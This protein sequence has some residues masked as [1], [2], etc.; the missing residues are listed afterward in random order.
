MRIINIKNRNIQISNNI[1]T[2]AIMTLAILLTLIVLPI[3]FLGLGKSSINAF[4]TGNGDVDVVKGGGITFPTNGK[5]KLYRKEENKV[6]ELDLEEYI[7]GVVASEVPANFSEEA[8]K[9]QAVA[10]RTFY[11]SKRVNPCKDAKSHEAEVCDTNNCQVYMSKEERLSKWSSKDGEDNW[12][13]IKKAVY[14]TKGQILTYD[15]SVLEYPQFFATSSGKTEDAKDVFSIDVPY[16]KSEESK[17]E[18]NAPKFKTNTEIPISEFINKINAKYPE[19]NVKADNLPSQ[20]KIDSHTDGGSVKIIRIGKE[21]IK[22]T[23]FRELF[24]L[25]SSNFTLEFNKDSIKINCT[26]YG[27]G[28]GMSQWGANAMAKNGDTYD[29]ILKHYYNGVKIAEIIYT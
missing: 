21:S 1:Y 15:G 14:D 16:L 13:K 6:E 11:M 25:N 22:G 29:N 10:A 18:E 17:G 26:G 5:V 19:A 24:N 23:Q 2:I 20:I 7:I 27:H 3:I 4:N 8:L 12:S 28:V 9:A